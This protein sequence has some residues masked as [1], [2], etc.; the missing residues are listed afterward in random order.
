M[1]T[2]REPGVSLDQSGVYALTS[3]I[4]HHKKHLPVLYAVAACTMIAAGFAQARVNDRYSKSPLRSWF[5]TL[6]SQR[7]GKCCGDFD[8]ITLSDVDWDTKDNH[9]RVRIG[10]PT[11]RPFRDAMGRREEIA[12][13]ALIRTDGS[14]QCK[15]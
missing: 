7:G 10:R 14:P 13:I 6:H 3:R 2:V 8:G 9:Y 11:H 12:S 1:T 5:E 15:R 4:R